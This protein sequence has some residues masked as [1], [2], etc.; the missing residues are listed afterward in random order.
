MGGK[1]YGQLFFAFVFFCFLKILV[2]GF[3]MV[4]SS[5]DGNRSLELFN[6]SFLVYVSNFCIMVWRM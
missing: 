3:V 2:D 6:Y 1:A 4:I 5:F